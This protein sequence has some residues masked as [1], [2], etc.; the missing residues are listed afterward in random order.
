M[1]EARLRAPTDPRLGLVGRVPLAV[2]TVFRCEGRQRGRHSADKLL[3]II[4]VSLPFDPTPSLS[5]FF[6]DSC[7]VEIKMVRPGEKPP[8]R[9]LLLRPL[10]GSL[11]SLV[12]LVSRR[13]PL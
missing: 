13:L 10:T 2:S 9:P 4:P 1:T 12:V 7:S 3:S 5:L 11:R 6:A 8:V